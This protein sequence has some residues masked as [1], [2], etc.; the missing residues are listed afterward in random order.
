MLQFVKNIYIVFHIVGDVFVPKSLTM[1]AN[2][3]TPPP[4]LS[5]SELI[6]DMDKHGIGTDAT[7]AAHISTIQQR[8]YVVKDEQNRF[9]PT[10][11]GIALIEAYNS[12]GY[13][14]NKPFLRAQM[15]AD[16]QKIARGECR[17][18]DVIRNCLEQMK[19]C[20]DTCVRESDK[21]DQAMQKYF[22]RMGGAES[23]DYVVVKQR[24]SKCGVCDQSMD[25][26]VRE[27]DLNAHPSAE[28][29]EDDGDDEEAE[30]GHPQHQ[31]GRGRGRNRGGG[32]AAR[33]GG[34]NGGRHGGRNGSGRGA[35]NGNVSRYLHCATC[36]RSHFLPGRGS[37]TAHDARCAVCQ[38]QVV[39]VKN[40]ETSKEHTVCPYCFK[41]V[42]LYLTSFPLHAEWLANA[43]LHSILTTMFSLLLF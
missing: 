27:T 25:L 30:N 5:E 9:I 40:L 6:S 1:T 28:D 34:R 12:M 17:K 19:I 23:Q 43:Y 41:L 11:L 16:C 8:E 33:G 38:F 24:F 39:T 15:E 2:R 10:K 26:K 14:L 21:L 42:A 35:N 31:G 32:G 37:L 36:Q 4:N 3:T 13:Q 18:E 20:F 29:S 7:I 22:T